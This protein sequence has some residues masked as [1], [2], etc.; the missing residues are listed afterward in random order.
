M[1]EPMDLFEKSEWETVAI[2]SN[3]A[4]ISMAMLMCGTVWKLK[5]SNPKYNLFG[6]FTLR[7]KFSM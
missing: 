3:L 1:F 4:L 7:F 6:T 5:Q 2:S